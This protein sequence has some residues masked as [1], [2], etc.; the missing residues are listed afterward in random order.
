M[1]LIKKDNI[2]DLL[3]LKSI[4]EYD[5]NIFKVL[6]FL[7][8]DIEYYLEQDLNYVQNSLISDLYNT[9]S[10]LYIKLNRRKST[11]GFVRQIADKP[12]SDSDF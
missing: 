6:L 1:N 12:F 10:P 11:V 3:L 5:Y 9:V 8:W 4:Y 2:N 7:Y